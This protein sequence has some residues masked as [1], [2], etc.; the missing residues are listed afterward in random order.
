MLFI[1]YNIEGKRERER[2]S[3]QSKDIGPVNCQTY[4]MEYSATAHATVHL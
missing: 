2:I 4:T 1:V 3:V